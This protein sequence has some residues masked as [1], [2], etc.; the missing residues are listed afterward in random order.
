[1]KH[2]IKT[3]EAAKRFVEAYDKRNQSRLVLSVLKTNMDSDLTPKGRH[4]KCHSKIYEEACQAHEPLAIEA[5]ESLRLLKISM[6]ED[7]CSDPIEVMSRIVGIKDDILSDWQGD[8]LKD[9][10]NLFIHASHEYLSK[11]GGE[12]HED[13]KTSYQEGIERMQKGYTS[14]I[15]IMG[16]VDRI[17]GN[18]GNFD[19]DG[20]HSYL[21]FNFGADG[22]LLSVY[23]TTAEGDY[24]IREYDRNHS[25]LCHEFHITHNAAEMNFCAYGTKSPSITAVDAASRIFLASITAKVCQFIKDGEDMYPRSFYDNGMDAF[26]DK[27]RAIASTNIQ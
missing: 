2:S 23:H 1:M 17:I 10:T 11:V 5:E 25:S 6:H 4:K 13:S 20:V 7:E 14:Y 8:G 3:I 24:Q 9:I 16:A 27:A 22:R 12:W 18:V 15:D 21:K 26:V 19:T